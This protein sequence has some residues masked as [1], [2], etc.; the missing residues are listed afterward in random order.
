VILPGSR[1]RPRRRNPSG[2]AT[3]D[4]RVEELLRSAG[5][6]ARTARHQVVDIEHVLVAVLAAPGPVGRFTRATAGWDARQPEVVKEILSDTQHGYQYVGLPD[7]NHLDP[8]A[9]PDT[10][11]TLGAVVPDP[12]DG[13]L[14]LLAER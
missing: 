6:A 10:Y 13:E 12:E 7:L 11:A 14:R 9:I 5:E 2:R 4:P 8:V 3:P 1:C